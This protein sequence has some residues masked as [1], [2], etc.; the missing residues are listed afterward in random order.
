MF[1]MGLFP[2]LFLEPMHL[3]VSNLLI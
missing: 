2:N 1:V 3:A